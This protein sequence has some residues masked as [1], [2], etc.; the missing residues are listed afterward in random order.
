VG[1]YFLRSFESVGRTSKARAGDVAQ[2]VECLPSKCEAL[3]SNSNTVK[4]K[5]NKCVSFLSNPKRF[6][7]NTRK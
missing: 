3:S 2:V 7:L 5:Q 1:P 6:F 4:N